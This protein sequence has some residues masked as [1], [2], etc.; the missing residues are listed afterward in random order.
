MG[1]LST[2]SQEL[3]ELAAKTSPAVVGVEHRMGNGTGLVLAHDEKHGLVAKARF[4][5]EAAAA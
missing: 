2:L 3:V 4:E 5:A 1:L